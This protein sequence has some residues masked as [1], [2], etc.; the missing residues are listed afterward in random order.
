MREHK[1]LEERGSFPPSGWTVL[2]RNG[3]GGAYLKPDN[4]IDDNKNNPQPFRHRPRP[5]P[6]PKPVVDWNEIQELF[7]AQADDLALNLFAK[8]LGVSV[9]A[10]TLMGCGWCAGKKSW[11]FPMYDEHRNI[12]GMRLRN[13]KGKFAIKGSTAG[14]FLPNL[15][16]DS[17]EEEERVYVC[18]GPT[19]TAAVLTM[20][21]YAIGRPSAGG[22][23]G[24]ICKLVGGKKVVI[25]SDGDPPGV[26]GSE[27][28]SVDLKQVGSRVKIVQPPAKDVR[29]WLND[30][31]SLRK[32]EE[33]VT[34]TK[35]RRDA[36]QQ[37]Q[38]KPA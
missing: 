3:D 23:S 6:E 22:A 37:V 33:L 29:A 24:A 5:K 31:G 34:Q 7:V 36:T 11:S 20:G 1:V 19:D 26:K 8:N 12:C 28:L 9:R 27:S 21:A 16:M 4:L 17:W 2:K 32:L 25:V 13:D 38:G 10:L 15:P 14:V 18:E 30:G 35:E